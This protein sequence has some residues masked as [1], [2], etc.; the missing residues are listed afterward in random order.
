M[1]TDLRQQSF[2]NR[3]PSVGP[4]RLR[5]SAWRKEGQGGEEGQKSKIQ[6]SKN[7][8]E[9]WGPTASVGESLSRCHDVWWPC[10]EDE[11]ALLGRAE[12]SDGAERGMP[13]LYGGTIP[14][15]FAQ[16]VSQHGDRPAVVAR[17]PTRSDSGGGSERTL[18]YHMLDVESNRLAWSLADL[19]VGKGDR[20]AV[21][22]GN[23]CEFA[24]LTYACFKL[25]A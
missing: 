17:R 21:S 4:S 5:Y 25:G 14:E 10:F 9:V 2:V 16:V 19:G 8:N 6:G 1:S 13:P 12:L 18:T 7:K 3:A 15:H 24:A 11:E 22:L 20:V 23:T